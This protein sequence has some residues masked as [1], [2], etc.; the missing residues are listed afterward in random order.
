MS[1]GKKV[2]HPQKSGEMMSK[3][4]DKESLESGLDH[5]SAQTFLVLV[6]QF[7][8]ESTRSWE[9]WTPLPLSVVDFSL[10]P[11]DLGRPAVK[12]KSHI[13]LQERLR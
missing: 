3:D 6:P 9:L 10:P 13:A 2:C 7:K 5:K 4:V 12:F 1:L 11:R 8:P